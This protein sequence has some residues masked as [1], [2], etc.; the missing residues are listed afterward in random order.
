MTEAKKLW[1]PPLNRLS[2]APRIQLQRPESPIKDRAMRCAARFSAPA[3][4]Q[5]IASARLRPNSVPSPVVTAPVPPPHLPQRKSRAPGRPVTF[6]FVG[7]TGVRKGLHHLLE[8]W[9][10]APAN[11]HLRLVGTREDSLHRLFSD[12]FLQPNVSCV[13][14][15]PNVADNILRRTFLCCRPLKRVIRLS[16]TK[17]PPMHCRSW[18]R[19]LGP[20]ASEQKPVQSL[21]SIPMISPHYAKTSRL[22]PHPTIS[23]DIGVN[24]RAAVVN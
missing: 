14:F 7:Q 21:H 2:Y 23:G 10:M 1:T 3:R 19:R 13:G 18:R 11:A 16:P 6:L 20:V 24:G 9:R 4:P 8:V 12:V 22:S 5:F 17:P 15:R